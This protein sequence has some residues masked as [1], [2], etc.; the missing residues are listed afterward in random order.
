MYF[1]NFIQN[2]DISNELESSSL[3]SMSSPI[4]I[5]D[6]ETDASIVDDG[7]YLC[8]FETIDCCYVH[9]CVCLIDFSKRIT[10]YL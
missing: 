7:P 5:S 4:I 6:D 2:S 8:M 10:F 1:S 3:I 9:M